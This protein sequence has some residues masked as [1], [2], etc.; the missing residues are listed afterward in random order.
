MKKITLLIVLFIS[1]ISYGQ[2]LSEDF[3]SGTFP[4][5]GWTLNSTNTNF[6]FQLSTNANGG[7]GAAE[8][9]YDPALVAQNETLISPSL[10]FTAATAPELTLFVNL[11]YF[12]AVDPNNNYDITISARQ[13]ANTTALWTEADLGVFTSFTWIEVT[14]DLTAYA[15]LNNVFVEINYTGTDGASFNLDDI[16]VEEAPACDIP[17]NLSFDATNLT[18]TTADV[19]W[20]NAG[21]FDIRYG[22]FPYA[23]RDAGGTVDTVLAGNSYQLTGLTPGVSYNVFVRQS[24]AGGLLSDWEEVI[25]GTTPVPGVAFPFDEDFEPDANQALV[26]NLGINYLSTTGNWGYRQDDLSDGDTTND[27]ASNGV[28]SVFS[29]STFTDAAAD[30]T[31]YLGPYTLA[32]NSQYTFS[33]QQ[34]NRV[35]SDATT[36]NKDIEVVAATTTD[37]TTN[38]LLATFDDMNNVTHQMR[39]GTFTPTAAGDYYFGIRDKSALLTGVTTANSVYAD[40]VNITSTLSVDDVNGI[41]L[42]YF[43]N[44]TTNNFNIE[45]TE[46]ILDNIEVYNLLGQ[47]VI[48]QQVDHSSASIDMNAATDGVYIAKINFNGKTRSIKFVK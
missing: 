4:P 26:L 32:A 24:C 14:L 28:G 48:H 8:V 18:N 15:G 35:V 43:F 39:S 27:Y 10:D 34:R 11:S 6:T 33:F 9:Q 2:F 46:G 45:I 40:A 37:G 29:N 7:T 3:E 5:A 41:D 30:A 19:T 44:S 23:V 22:E 36:P 12:W 38:T 42:N 16:L 31:I 21:N 1:A 25:V 17:N 20:D 13:G 47:Q